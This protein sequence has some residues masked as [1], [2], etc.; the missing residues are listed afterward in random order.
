MVRP[1]VLNE[2]GVVILAQNQNLEK[3]MNSGFLLGIM[4]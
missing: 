4:N 2:E 1:Q 3:N